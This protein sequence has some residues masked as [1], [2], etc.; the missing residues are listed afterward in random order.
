MSAVTN[1]PGT[2]PDVDANGREVLPNGASVVVT[3]MN[4]LGVPKSVVA[5]KFW[6]YRMK[7][8]I[9]AAVLPGWVNGGS[10]YVVVDESNVTG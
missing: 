1:I 9:C 10:H 2:T 7:L 4:T 3:Y 6:K 8:A 5:K